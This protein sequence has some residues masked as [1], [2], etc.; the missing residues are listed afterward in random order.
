MTGTTISMTGTTIT[1]TGTTTG[2]ITSGGAQ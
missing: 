1:M 2:T